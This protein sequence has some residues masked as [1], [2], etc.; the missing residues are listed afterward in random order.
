MPLAPSKA[1]CIGLAKNYLSASPA[2]ADVVNPFPA[3]DADNAASVAKSIW[4]W[5][6]LSPADRAEKGIGWFWISFGGFERFS[7]R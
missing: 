1:D 4:R 7:G 3:I 5:I 6:V 2:D